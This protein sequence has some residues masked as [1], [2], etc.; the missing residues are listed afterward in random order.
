MELLT[1]FSATPVSFH[2][3]SS[4]SSRRI[5]HAVPIFEKDTRRPIHIRIGSNPSIIIVPYGFFMGIGFAALVF[6][7][8]TFGAPSH[9]GFKSLS[10]ALNLTLFSAVLFARLLSIIME[11]G[12]AM[13]ITRPVPTLLRPGFWLHGGIFGAAAGASLAWKLGHVESFSMFSGSLAVGLPLY[14]TFSRI[15]CHTYGCCYGRVAELSNN[16]S[17]TSQTL[18]RLLPFPAV[19]YSHPTHYAVT[20]LNPSLLDKPLVPIQLI[21]AALFLLL[22]LFVSLPI[23]CITTVELAGSTTLVC[24]AAVRLIT[25]AYRADYRGQEGRRLS[26]TGKM[27]LIQALAGVVW[28]FCSLKVAWQPHYG[29][30]HVG[31]PYMLGGVQERVQKSVFAVAFGIAVYGVHIGEVGAWAITQG[32][33]QR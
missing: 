8:L 30:Q 9:H 28:L 14:E 21:S 26:M 32:K 29:E 13:I 1:V 25:E 10:Y 22:F 17:F 2:R 16:D 15:G 12:V 11:D 31:S 20:R 4:M 23:V 19:R 18:W 24:H 27:A 5:T 6:V 3:Y 7:S 33:E